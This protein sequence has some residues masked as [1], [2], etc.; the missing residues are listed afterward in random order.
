MRDHERLIRA[1]LLDFY[2]TLAEM[3]PPE[4]TWADVL[5]ERGFTYDED[6]RRRYWEEGIDGTEHDEHSQ[7]RDHYV[8]WQ[9]ARTRVMLAE[10]GVP[11][12]QQAD[13]VD[14]MHGMLTSRYI[15]GYP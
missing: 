7:S 10:C 5:S 11:D 14:E 6:A 13:L 9:K 3:T 1:I 12:D 2:G 4:R 8:A 15:V